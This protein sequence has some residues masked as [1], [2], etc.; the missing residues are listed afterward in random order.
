[1]ER[2]TVVVEAT[3]FYIR[4]FGRQSH[5]VEG[6]PSSELVGEG[7]PANA[8]AK[9]AQRKHLQ[10][11]QQQQQQQATPASSTSSS[12]RHKHRPHDA[13]SRHHAESTHSLIPTGGEN[14]PVVHRFRS[15]KRQLRRA[16]SSL[17]EQAAKRL[18]PK[19]QPLH[20]LATEENNTKEPVAFRVI[21]ESFRCLS[22]H[23]CGASYEA[24]RRAPLNTPARTPRRIPPSQ[25]PA[26]CC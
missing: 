2:L 23:C 8:P 12:H 17:V 13:Q 3:S 5:H 25:S 15:Q 6:K 9:A 20:A 19:T 11:Q 14:S 16:C 18:V 4:Y 21:C 10:Q 7:G 24:I 1:M 26:G 22:D